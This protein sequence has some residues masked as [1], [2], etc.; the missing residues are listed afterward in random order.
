FAPVAL[1]GVAGNARAD[2]DEQKRS[3]E[4]FKAGLAAGKA[5]DYAQAEAAFRASYALRLSAS[6]LRNWALA[7]MKLG[8][9]VE[10]LAHL[11]LAAGWS[12]WTAE[13]RRIVQE[14]L[15][16]AYAA[17]GHLAIKT[18]DGA[19]IAIDGVLL[20]AAAPLDTVVDVAAGMR[21]VDAG[22]GPR[23]ARAEVDAQAG[24]VVDVTIPLPAEAPQPAPVRSALVSE[25]MPARAD[26]SSA[27][28]AS[29]WWTAPHAV[30]VGLGATAALGA[31]L[32]VYFEAA[33][34]AA[35]SDASTLRASIGPGACAGAAAPGQ[36]GTLRDKIAAVHQDETLADLSFA[37][38]GAAA[39][40]AAVVLTVLAPKAALRTGTVRWAPAVAPGAAG[41]AGS[42]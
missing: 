5:A 2:G 36:C 23:T 3:A 21:N 31:G 24:K 15:D 1:L 26:V 30:A 42:F 4:F 19:H 7:E 37:V 33:S 6:T 32:G 27:R 10:A 13:Q 28:D 39:V 9:M 22:L 29:T 38:G 41:V 35:S 12:G 25:P 34:H 18:M 17:T 16:D 40:G 8:K 20:E 14:N 11:R